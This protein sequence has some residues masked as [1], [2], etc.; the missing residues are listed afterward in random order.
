MADVT[1]SETTIEK[2]T[3]MGTYLLK[4]LYQISVSLVGSVGGALAGL[5]ISK[6]LSKGAAPEE[7]MVRLWKGLPYW[8]TKI[9]GLKLAPT[10]GQL[11]WGL[12][13]G[14]LIGTIGSSVVLGYEHWKKIKQSQLQVDEITRD[15][16]DIEVFKKTDPELA[17][18]NERL[19]AELHKREKEGHAP[20][21]HHKLEEG[22]H[23]TQNAE[24]GHD[25]HAE[26]SGHHAGA[27]WKDKMAEQA[28]HSS[29]HHR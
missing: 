15:I 11:K 24:H 7:H 28:E 29:E 20:T 13:G 14:A 23:H 5:G 9:P 18:E 10:S 2:Q 25:S 22:A 12:G 17:A 16:S 4:Q 1:K 6:A 26:K 8:I 19:W 21:P 3:S 27:S